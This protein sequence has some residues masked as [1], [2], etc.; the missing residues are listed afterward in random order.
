M[1]QLY[2]WLDNTFLY[3]FAFLEGK[4]ILI[5]AGPTYEPI[6]PVRF[7]GNHST[8]KMGL[9]LANEAL[10][11]GAHGYLL[12]KTSGE[13]LL[14][15]LEELQNGGSPMSSVIAR[16]VIEVFEVRNKKNKELELLTNREA[17]ILELLAKGY[18]YKEI[19]SKLNLTINTVKQYIHTIYEK[20]HVQNRTEALNKAFP[21][22]W[23]LTFVGLPGIFI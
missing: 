1:K 7:I 2:F 9:A 5:S 23:Y 6:D 20:L 15:A 18:L 10:K 13:K 21:K 14:E 3:F 11:A 16:K 19:A 22:N 4:K 12:K 8:G 17:E